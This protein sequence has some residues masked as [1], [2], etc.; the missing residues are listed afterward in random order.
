MGVAPHA[1][2]NQGFQG[3]A[4]WRRWAS[5]RATELFKKRSEVLSFFTQ[6]RPSFHN[7][8]T[9]CSTRSY[10]TWVSIWVVATLS[11]PSR[12]WMST[13]SAPALSRLVA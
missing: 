1:Q 4:A 2:H 12:A 6:A 13:R 3:E 11:W 5:K 10:P 7:R 9:T 8:A